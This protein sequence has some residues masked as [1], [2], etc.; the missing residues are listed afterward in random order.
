MLNVDQPIAGP[1]IREARKELDISQA[2]FAERL[3]TTRRRVIAWESG[4]NIPS[5]MYLRRIAE[6]TGK[7]IEFFLDGAAD[8][9]EER[10]SSAS[11][12]EELMEALRPLARLLSQDRMFA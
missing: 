7:S 6:S 8:D 11:R 4:E 1:R 12:E 3:G 9:P 5:A 2:R 10:L